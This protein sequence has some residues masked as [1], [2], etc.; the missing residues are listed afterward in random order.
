M[1]V[2]SGDRIRELFAAL[3]GELA[4]RSVVGEVG[5][6]GGAVMCPALSGAREHAAEYMLA[7]T[8]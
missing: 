2:P 4:K 6:L 1:S 3:D 8:P 5:P 7:M